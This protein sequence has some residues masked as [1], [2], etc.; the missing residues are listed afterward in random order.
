MNKEKLWAV[1]IPEE[2][3]SELL[4]PVPSQKIGKQLVYRLKKEAL[5]AFPKVGH[6][7]ADSITFKSGKAAKKIM[8][9]I[10]KKTK[11]GG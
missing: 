5:Q 3:D 1:N 11:T 8:K 4:H 9:N 10:F 2:P 6:S 7:I